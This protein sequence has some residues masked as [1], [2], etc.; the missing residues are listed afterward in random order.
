MAT[1]ALPAGVGAAALRALYPEPDSDRQVAHDCADSLRRFIV[2][3]WPIVEPATPF[4]TSWH[5]D[6]VC[7]HLEAVSAGELRRLIIN[8]PP[9]TMKS[10][11]VSVLWP[12]WEWL[13]KPW[14]RWVFA[15]Y[16]ESLSIRDSVKMR[17]LI[18][19]QGGRNDGTL[20]QRVGYRGLLGQLH[21]EPWALTHD[22]NVKTKYETTESGLRLATSVGGTATG[23]G[24]DRIVIDD[25]LNAKQARSETER[26]AANVWWDE[27]MTTRFNNDEAAGVIVMQ[28]LHQQDLTGH[29]LAQG[30]WHHLCLPAEYEPTHPFVYPRSARLASGRVLAGDPRR[31]AGELLDPVRLGPNRLAELRRGLGSYAYAGQMQQRPSP[32]EGGMF[33][34]SWWR[35]WEPGFENTLHLGWDRVICSWDLRF[36]DSQ[37]ASSSYVVGQAWGV[38]GADRYLLGQIRGQMSFTESVKAVQALA[39]WRPDATTKLVERKA[40]GAA[41]IDT[42][43]RKVT[44]LI[45]VEPE[46]GKEAR[47]AAVSPLVEAGNV[48]L[49]STDLIP[50]PL[51]WPATSAQE[52]IEEHAVFPNGTHDDQVDAMTQALNW[53]GMPFADQSDDDMPVRVGSESVTAGVLTRPM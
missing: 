32:L 33:K 4:V 8:V 45:P 38:H 26:R 15:S 41:V 39:R 21:G 36:G 42:L 46:G 13:R 50:C 18:E 7:E 28:R 51:G 30:G 24:G 47:A 6:T 29:L 1:D 49:P 20:L 34:R 2:E 43:R 31:K 10:L 40:N 23:E 3:A 37:K 48:Y 5:I 17:R 25:P 9:R 53:V 19:S 44:G 16:A 35:H 22:Q 52:F 27:T 12:A 14:L 11:S